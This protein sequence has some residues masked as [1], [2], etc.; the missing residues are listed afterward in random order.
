MSPVENARVPVPSASQ[1]IL[2]NFEATDR[3]AMLVLNR[4]FPDSFKT[5][6]FRSSRQR[7]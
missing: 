5:D 1:Y 7:K 6:S 3:I 2:D 4:E